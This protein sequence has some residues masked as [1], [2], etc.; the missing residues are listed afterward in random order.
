VTP[1]LDALYRDVILDHNRHPRHFHV[2]DGATSAERH[3]PFCGD[4]LTVYL[5][6]HD[7]VI[8]DA[9]FQGVACA[10]AKASASLMTEQVIGRTRDE[11][12]TIFARLCAAIETP[13]GAAVED[14]GSLSALTGIRQFPARLKCATLPWQA[15][16]AALPDP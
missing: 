5:R 7:G 2:L 8:A 9:S 10:I 12:E 15:L 3:N 16:L 13:V 6:V 11:A 1:D 4:R 14:L